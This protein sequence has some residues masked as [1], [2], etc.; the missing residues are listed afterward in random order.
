MSVTFWDYS[1]RARRIPFSAWEVFT[2]VIPR[3]S[4]TN[5]NHVLYFPFEVQSKRGMTMMRGIARGGKRAVC[6]VVLF[7]L[8][9]ALDVLAQQDAQVRREVAALG[10]GFTMRLEA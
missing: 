7:V 8:A 4:C 2:P 9:R 6:A 3:A 10:D 1:A 5:G